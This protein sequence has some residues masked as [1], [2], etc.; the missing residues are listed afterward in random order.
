M[1]S[2]QRR[3]DRQNS[4]GP[5]TT[6]VRGPTSTTISARG[7]SSEP[8]AAL[9]AGSEGTDFFV[10]LL[11]AGGGGRVV[12][13]YICLTPIGLRK[14]TGRRSSRCCCCCQ[15]CFRPSRLRRGTC[16]R[17]S[18][19]AVVVRLVSVLLLLFSDLFQAESS[20][21]RYVRA[22]ISS[23]CCCQTCVSAVVVVRLVSGRVVSGEV[24]A[25][26]S[27]VVAVVVRSASVLLLLFSDLFQA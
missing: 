16:G 12:C 11:G 19:V 3:S 8:L 20:P 1:P 4:I 17:S 14:G 10:A 21:E 13:R 6:A 27:S 18:V 22:K 26:E 25:G 5:V 24:R 15:T 23:C 9:E 2:A 7:R